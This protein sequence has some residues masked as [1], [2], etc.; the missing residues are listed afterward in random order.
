MSTNIVMD[1]DQAEAYYHFPPGFLDNAARR[2][3]GPPFWKLSRRT[4]LY[5]KADLDAWLAARRIEPQK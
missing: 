3:T 4:I 2:R 1:R 5:A